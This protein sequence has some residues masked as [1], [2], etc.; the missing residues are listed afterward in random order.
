MVFKF[1]NFRNNTALIEENGQILK[2]NEFYDFSVEIKKVLNQRCLAFSFCSNT[3]GSVLGYTHFL[4][5]NIVQALINKDLDL[6]M[7][8]NLIDEYKPSYLWIPK[9]MQNKFNFE[10]VF[11]KYDYALVKTNFEID[12]LLNDDLALLL[13]TSGS[14]GSP[15][16]VRQSYKNIISNTNSIVSYLELNENERPITTLPMNYTYGL[17]IINT[18]LMVGAT[19]LLTD[20]KIMEKEFWQFLNENKA[21]SFG[22]VPYTYEM[23]DKLRF[24]RKDTSS[25]V[26]MTQAGGKITKELHLKVAEFAKEHNKKF[27][28][29]YGQTEA[30]A[31]MGYLPYDKALSKIGSMGI[32]IPGGEFSI[33]D[34]ENK[35]I[36]E[37][38]KVGELVY[39]GDN[40]TMG[41]AENRFDLNKD[42]DNNGKLYTADMAMFDEDGFYYIVGRK[43][44]FLK[45]FGNRVNL[46]ETERILKTEFDTEIVCSGIDDNM[47]IFVTVSNLEKD[48]LKFVSDK[49]SINSHG[50]NVVTVSEIEKNDS[51]KIKYSS[52]DKYFKE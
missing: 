27:V 11:E 47:Y 9:E 4:N 3:I 46:D 7:I 36:K 32:A 37:P 29:M 51:G 48:I 42:D 26:T 16:F 40:V 49:L 28:V 43:K 50:F 34:A 20:K 22:G 6:N 52:F 25:I 30:T 17:S 23:L 15:K 41:Y 2:Y 19:I 14:T 45:L 8:N 33:I 44:R 18:H 13:T 31:R 35:E 38:N 12:Y 24:F 5:N 1:D 21:T 10:T 39:I